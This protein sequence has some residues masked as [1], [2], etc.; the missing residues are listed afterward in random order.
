MRRLWLEIVGYMLFLLVFAPAF[1]LNSWV[2]L[3]GGKLSL[4]VQPQGTL[5]HGQ[6]VLLGVTPV[7]WQVVP[8]TLWHGCLGVNMQIDGH[9]SEWQ[10]CPGQISVS[11]FD[12]HMPVGVLA[13]LSPM[14]M[15][16]QPSGQL[17]V[18]ASDIQVGRQTRGQWQIDWLDAG[19]A[20]APVNP[21]GSWRVSGQGK[22]QMQHFTLHD[23]Q[24]PVHIQGQGDWQNG[25]GLQWQGE[26]WT[27][28]KRL[29]GVLNML[30]TVGPDGRVR[31][32]VAH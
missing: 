31:F 23:L 5:W 2:T 20:A 13:L 4:L 9:V 22:G 18:T 32:A 10:L 25:R 11:R 6:G 30:G 27:E 15:K 21:L 16:W 28:D 3:P 24:G 12:V 14:A 17:H 7:R 19:V 1:L 26:V 8:S 29:F